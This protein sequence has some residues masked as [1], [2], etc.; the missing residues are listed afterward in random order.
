MHTYIRKKKRYGDN[1]NMAMEKRYGNRKK[2]YGNRKKNAATCID[3]GTN[4]GG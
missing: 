1:K 2:R 3:A 4:K